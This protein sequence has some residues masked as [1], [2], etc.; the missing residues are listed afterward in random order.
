VQVILLLASAAWAGGTIVAL[1]GAVAPGPTAGAVVVTPEVIA[2]DPRWTPLDEHAMR[3][4]GEE[5]LAVRP[6]MHE[7]DGELEIMARLEAAVSNVHVLRNEEEKRLLYVALAFQGFAVQRYFQDELA[8]D[9]AAEP[10]RVVVGDHVEVKAWVDAIALD[11]FREPTRLDISEA[12]ELAAFQATRARMLYADPARFYATDVRTDAVVLVDGARLGTNPANGVDLPPGRHLVT[13]LSDGHIVARQEF[14]V[15]PGE[16]W[17]MSAPPPRSD[18]DA[19]IKALASRPDEARIPDRLATTL[20]ELP[21]PVQIAVADTSGGDALLYRVEGDHLVRE[22]ETPD[23]RVDGATR[24]PWMQADLRTWVGA[25]WVHDDSYHLLNDGAPGV[26]ST[27]NAPAPVVGVGVRYELTDEYGAGGGVDLY[28][29][30]GQ[31]HSLPTGSG[32]RRL[33]AYPHASIGLPPLQL[34][35]GVMTPWHLGLGARFQLPL[36]GSTQLCG[37]VVLGTASLGGG[38]AD[39][40]PAAPRSAFVGLSSAF[41]S[42]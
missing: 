3:N 34:S 22:A 14:R 17:R 27:T 5:L 31:W 40:E 7:F 20:A 6:L 33:R 21:G 19:L 18:V 29:P 35:L 39:V 1:D 32:E 24:S 9:P 13:M 42:P 10:Y 2:P 12:P 26:A 38:N 37:A 23:P 36:A 28:A 41:G 8:T 25:G 15:G 4:L 30:T 11:P 16:V